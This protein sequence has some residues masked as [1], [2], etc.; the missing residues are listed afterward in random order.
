VSS[1]PDDPIVVVPSFNRA[2]L[3][4]E[5]LG[6]LRRQTLAHS[7]LVVD[8]GSTD[9]TGA[10]LAAR[11]PEVHV[12]E[13]PENIGFGRAINRGVGACAADTLV[14]LNND[15]VCHRPDF[16]E[17][18]VAGLDPARGVVMAGGV[19]LDAEDSD[20]ID[21]AGMEFDRTLLAYDYLH[22]AP[23]AV[24]ERQLP[25]PLGPCAGAAAFDRAAFLAVG[26]FDES[27]FAYLEDVDLVARLLVAGGRCR[28]VRDARALHHHSSTLGSG[29]KRKNEL[30]GWSRGY[31]IAKYRLHRR[32]RLLARALVAEAAI[33][34]GQL[35]VDRTAVGLLARMRGFR[36]GLRSPPASLPDPT[37]PTR[38]VSTTAALR[39]RLR[40]RA[41][42]PGA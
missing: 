42:T 7:V 26:G 38:P 33:A 13:L 32:P 9:G 30:M 24:L 25:D 21:T 36:V 35:L 12:L 28:L 27:Y 31:T 37:G 8:N 39:Q 18:L 41:L 14:L 29:S 16:L 1:S 22:G 40:R 15:V 10:M 19:L 17:R 11:C 6:S 34:A 23:A 4:A 5:L 2:D 20:R 3:L